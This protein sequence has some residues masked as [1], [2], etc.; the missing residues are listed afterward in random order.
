MRIAELIIALK[1]LEAKF[2]R[3]SRFT[4][5][6][7]ADTLSLYCAIVDLVTTYAAS[8]SILQLLTFAVRDHS[9]VLA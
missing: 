3:R 1:A 4:I 2:Q 5:I 8:D 6:Q 9:V 7:M